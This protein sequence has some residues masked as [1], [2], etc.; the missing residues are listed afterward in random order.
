MSSGLGHTVIDS[1]AG[2]RLLVAQQID[3]AAG[4]TVCV[5]LRPEKIQIETAAG[6][7]GSENSFAGRV[8]DVGYLGDMSVYKVKLDNGLDMRAVAAN[9]TRLIERPIGG[10]DRVW[11]SW[12]PE[13]GVVLTQ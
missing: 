9:R 8:V 12:P 3:A 1:I 5:A 7:V 6:R 2:G 4:T 13:A 11:L 10:N